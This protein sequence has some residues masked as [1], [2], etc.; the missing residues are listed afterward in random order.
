MGNERSQRNLKGV[1]K[2]DGDYVKLTDLDTAG[3]LFA[4]GVHI[5]YARRVSRYKFEISLYDPQKRAEELAIEYV[6]SCCADTCD[7]IRR[8]KAVIHQFNGRDDRKNGQVPG[9]VRDS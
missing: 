6:N 5:E 3:Y 4:K 8:L 1:L 9:R 7:A 2:R